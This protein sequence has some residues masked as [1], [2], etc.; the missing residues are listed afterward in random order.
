VPFAADG[1][2]STSPSSTTTTTK[3]AGPLSAAVLKLGDLPS[4]WTAAP[5]PSSS[6]ELCPGQDPSASVRPSTTADATFQ[7]GQTGP[8]LSSLLAAFKDASTAHAFLARSQAAIAACDS[9]DVSGVTYHLRPIASPGVGD[10]S[11][12]AELSSDTTLGG[13]VHG[14]V[15]YARVGSRVVT[16]VFGGAGDV[17]EA[18]AGRALRTVAARL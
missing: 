8:V 16:I 4:G 18:L 6:R 2:S 13:G 17:D 9:Y 5:H 12:G 14:R 11:I 1:S 15:L 10:E 3:V 7:Q